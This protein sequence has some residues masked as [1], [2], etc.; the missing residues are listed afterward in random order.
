MKEHKAS[1]LRALSSLGWNMNDIAMILDLPLN[2][3]KKELYL[4]GKKIGQSLL[5]ENKINQR[6]SIDEHLQQ[7]HE[8]CING[9][10]SIIREFNICFKIVGNKI[11]NII[12]FPHF[13]N[14]YFSQ[15]QRYDVELLCSQVLMLLL[16]DSYYRDIL[17]ANRL[18]C[19]LKRRF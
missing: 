12:F 18:F 15:E 2:T 16:T 9:L 13:T 6:Y 5:D 14:Y 11:Q 17:L 10:N 1:E 8:R 4:T 3:V 7:K 19:S